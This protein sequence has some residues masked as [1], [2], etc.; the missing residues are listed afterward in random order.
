MASS[1]KPDIVNYVMSKN[2]TV[3]FEQYHLN[4]GTDPR[5]D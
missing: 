5:I 3:P 2:I 1:L 4:K